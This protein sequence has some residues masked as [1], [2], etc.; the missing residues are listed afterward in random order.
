MLECRGDSMEYTNKYVG[1]RIREERNKR[2]LTIEELSELINITPAFLGLIERGKRG[3]RINK[4]CELAD[5]F[6]MSL[7]DLL[8]RYNTECVKET[9][10]E[11]IKY[12]YISNKSYE[13]DRLETLNLLLRNL[14]D[15]ELDFIIN[16]VKSFKKFLSNG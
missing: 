7:D 13:N 5:I 4:L 14:K 6:N 8:Q 2:K 3:I 11:G 15:Y 9:S 10:G 1:Q 16:F 12:T